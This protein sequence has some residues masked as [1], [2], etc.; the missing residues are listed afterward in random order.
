MQHRLSIMLDKETHEELHK[1]MN[2]SLVAE[3]GVTMFRLFEGSSKQAWYR[4]VMREGMRA[5][6]QFFERKKREIEANYE[7]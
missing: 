2:Y 1:L 3:E 7:D 4:E 5:K 6:R